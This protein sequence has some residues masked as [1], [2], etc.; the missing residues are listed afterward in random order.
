VGHHLFKRDRLAT[1]F[2]PECVRGLCNRCHGITHAEPAWF[3]KIMFGLISERR[4]SELARL[5]WS[6]VPAM[7]YGAARADLRGMLDG[8]KKAVNF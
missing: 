8:F 4:Y 5:S 6:V 1:A 7:D 2:H 3:M